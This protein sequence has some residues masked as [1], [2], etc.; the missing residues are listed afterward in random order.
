MHG[1]DGEQGAGRRAR[2]ASVQCRAVG[3][4]PLPVTLSMRPPARHSTSRVLSYLSLPPLS[5]SP[6]SLPPLVPILRSS[7]S[8]LAPHRRWRRV[9]LAVAPP[10]ASVS[11]SFCNVFSPARTH[12]HASASP[13]IYHITHT[14]THTHTHKHTHLEKSS[15]TSTPTSAQHP[16]D[17]PP[18]PTNPLHPSTATED[19]QT[20]RHTHT[21]NT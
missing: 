4:H 10:V 15:R 3:I 21:H 12:A 5:S 13:H 8:L 1:Q 11:A 6:L 20:D 17:P 14:H 7:T 16:P 2:D 19:R 18:P 9:M